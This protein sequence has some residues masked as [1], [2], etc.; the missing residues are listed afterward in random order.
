MSVSVVLP[1]L[2][3]VVEGWANHPELWRPLV[4]HDEHERV[5][6]LLHRDDAIELYVV[7]WTD[8]HDTGFHDHD[9][10]AAAIG[11]LE[12]EVTEQRLAL[13]GTVA[14]TL[15]RG[16]VVTIAREAI[17]RVRHTGTDPA[18]TLHAYSPPLERVGAYEVAKDGALLR[19]PRPA[20]VP[21]Q[22]VA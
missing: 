14:A 19:H 22:A 6:A 7:C 13:T 9:Q 16:D 17:H 10:S 20:E 4:R 15:T 18:V 5:Y 11:V 1:D 3:Q 8:G 2:E 21:L 12:G